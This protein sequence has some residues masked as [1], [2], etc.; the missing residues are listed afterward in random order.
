MVVK[1]KVRTTLFVLCTIVFFV[2]GTYAILAMQGL[3]F[4]FSNFKITKSGSIYVNYTP[5]SGTFSINSKLYPKKQGLF[6]GGILVS[7]LIPKTYQI[8]IAKDGYTP[9]TKKLSVDPGKVSVAARITLW[10]LV[11]FKKESTSTV[12]EFFPTEKGF[13]FKTK[14]GTITFN[15]TRIKGDS[16]EA[17]DMS[18][19]YIITKT[20]LNSLLLTDLNTPT[21]T[22]DFRV[23]FRT[24]MQ[25]Q[26]IIDNSAIQRTTFHP[27]SKTK[28]LVQTVN[29]MYVFDLKKNTIESIDTETHP[30]TFG[31]STNEVFVINKSGDL[32]VKNLLLGSRY[33]YPIDASSTKTITPSEDGNFAFVTQK[34]GTLFLFDK[35]KQTLEKIGSNTTFASFSSDGFRAIFIDS[36]NKIH[37]YYLD[38]FEGDSIKEKGTTESF[39]LPT[40]S[41]SDTFVWIPFAENYGMIQVGNTIRTIELDNRE[42]HNTATV[43]KNITSASLISGDLFV[44]TTNHDFLKGTLEE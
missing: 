21:T 37:I 35:T 15:N 4:D 40:G 7:N 28:L 24:V 11:E 29:G 5:I 30:A 27:F 19:S 1:K 2:A 18:S 44:I 9:W 14:E 42:P 16:M 25:G 12:F 20:D 36:N 34:N 3:V 22:R 39:S 43:A 23:L 41:I 32:V 38:D 26:D 13:V 10:K 33:I 6:G 17:F 31:I 8:S